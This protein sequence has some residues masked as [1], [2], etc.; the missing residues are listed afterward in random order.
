ME[1]C[2]RQSAAYTLRGP[3]Q[4]KLLLHA[5][6]PALALR[7]RHRR[8]QVSSMHGHRNLIFIKYDIGIKLRWISHI[9]SVVMVLTI[10]IR[11][12]SFIVPNSSNKV[13]PYQCFCLALPISFPY[14]CGN[15]LLVFLNFTRCDR[16]LA[17]VGFGYVK[18]NLFFPRVKAFSLP[19]FT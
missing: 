2:G 17:H 10:L 7:T 5:V 18:S 16:G 13:S 12:A 9:R 19:D 11:F 4:R 14:S 8:H 1:Q 3:T 6:S 15:K